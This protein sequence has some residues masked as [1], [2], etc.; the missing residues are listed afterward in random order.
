[1]RADF[2]YRLRFR[3]NGNREYH[4]V[5]GLRDPHLFGNFGYVGSLDLTV[6]NP[7]TIFFAP[8]VKKYM[9]AVYAFDAT[10][11]DQRVDARIGIH[12][13][14]AIAS[15]MLSSQYPPPATGVLQTQL[16]PFA[17]DSDRI[18]VGSLF[19]SGDLVFVGVDLEESTV[20][21]QLRAL[22]Q[23]GVAL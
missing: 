11:M 14:D 7:A 23:I 15:N 10:Y 1:M 22:A 20:S 13:I 17:L 12:Y 2:G 9:R 4:S 3:Q 18:L 16:F 19:Y 8:T 21:W 5:F 6:I